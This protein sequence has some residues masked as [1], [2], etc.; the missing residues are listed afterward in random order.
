MICSPHKRVI[1]E[2]KIIN[3]PKG[4]TSSLFLIL[5]A[6]KI[7]PVSA[8]KKN[9]KKS[10]MMIYLQP[11]KAPIMA[12]SLTSPPPIASFLKIT[13]PP[14]PM[15]NIIPPPTTTPKAEFTNEI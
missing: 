13:E 9:P 8:P 2:P 4:I 10:E 12:A 15:I 6:I 5:L 3:G 7:I 11:R 1:K 14:K